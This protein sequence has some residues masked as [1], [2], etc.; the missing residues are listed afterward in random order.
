MKKQKS[1]L[2]RTAVTVAGEKI[3]LSARTK[4]ELEEK[5]RETK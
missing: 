1:G 3:W 2:Y 4:A 5:K